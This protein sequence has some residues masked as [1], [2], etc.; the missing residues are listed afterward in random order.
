MMQ[1]YNA[2]YTNTF[3]E[4]TYDKPENTVLYNTEEF[5]KW[6][7]LWKARL[8]RQKEDKL[9]STELMRQSNPAIIPRNHR[10]EEAL[11]AAVNNDDYSVM[12]RLIDVLSRP[13]AH[14]NDQAEY[15]KLPPKCNSPYRT[16][17]GT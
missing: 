5:T 11:E 9:L 14:T 4:L 8:E 17:C 15:T 13:Y 16:F 12:E 10:V 6:Y 1:K 2:D 7:E 3:S